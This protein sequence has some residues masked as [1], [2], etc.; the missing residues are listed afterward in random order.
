MPNV[1]EVVKISLDNIAGGD[2]VG[3]FDG[4]LFVLEVKGM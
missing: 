3:W 1:V 2:L 4:Y